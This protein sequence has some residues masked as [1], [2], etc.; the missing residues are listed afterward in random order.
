MF[1]LYFKIYLPNI[2]NYFYLVNILVVNSVLQLN[3]FVGSYKYDK[4]LSDL[5]IL[6]ISFNNILLTRLMLKL[7]H[8]QVGK[9][10]EVL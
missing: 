7:F 6:T 5:T 8:K 1:F 3:L 9:L 4:N 10:P 2:H